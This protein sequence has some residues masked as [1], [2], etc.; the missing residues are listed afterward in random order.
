MK[1]LKPNINLLKQ[2]INSLKTNINSNL[3]NTVLP[4]LSGTEMI[5]P[6]EILSKISLENYFV[7]FDFNNELMSNVNL[8]KVV[9]L[10]FLL[11]FV[12]YKGDRMLDAEEYFLEN[13]LNKDF[14]NTKNTKN[15]KEDYYKSLIKNKSI[16]QFT[17]F[18][19]YISIF[20]IL[21]EMGNFSNFSNGSNGIILCLPLLISTFSYKSIKKLNVP[22]KPFY[23]T[24]LWTYVSCI[25]PMISID[26]LHYGYLHYDVC[27]PLLL[28]IF[29]TTNIADIKDYKEDKDNNISTL[30]TVIGKEESKYII[31]LCALFSNYVFVQQ[32]NFSL[33][34]QNIFFIVSN[35][36]SLF[37]LYRL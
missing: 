32:D 4:I 2:N 21:I 16:V 18:V 14:K 33:N 31:I 24:L 37:T 30:P 8:K 23:V 9:L 20:V 6:I 15:S 1:L 11:S 19:S 28:N 22:I 25:L 12:T 26:N 29:A 17:L 5:I 35:I 7:D 36:G 13:E 10:C 27:I 3:V 34:L